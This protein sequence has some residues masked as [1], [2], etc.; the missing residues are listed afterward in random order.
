MSKQRDIKISQQLCWHELKSVKNTFSFNAIC[1]VRFLHSIY[2]IEDRLGMYI[3]ALSFFF[4]VQFSLDVHYNVQTT[5]PKPTENNSVLTS[6]C[7][8]PN[9]FYS[10][11]SR[12]FFFSQRFNMWGLW[13][14][15][16]S[17]SR[18]N[19]EITKISVET[20]GGKWSQKHVL[21]RKS[22]VVCFSSCHP[23]G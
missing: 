4:S 21:A 23:I 5:P 6:V 9:E 22:A 14:H 20:A 10:N 2:T 1:I 12:R 11:A 16:C 3:Y 8:S 15:V 17:L 18:K 7:F 13:N 19:F